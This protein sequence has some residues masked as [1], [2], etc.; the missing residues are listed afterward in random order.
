MTA[1][2]ISAERIVGEFEVKM[3]SCFHSS[4]LKLLNN[5]DRDG[6]RVMRQV[7][8]SEFNKA[9][10]ALFEH[11]LLLY[12]NGSAIPHGENYVSFEQ[13]LNEVFD[14]FEKHTLS[15]NS[16]NGTKLMGS[17]LEDDLGKLEA[18]LRREYRRIDGGSAGNGR[19]GSG[20]H[21]DEPESPV[22]RTDQEPRL[23]PSF[24]TI[25]KP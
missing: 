7:I 15:Y 22:G 16:T 8:I 2:A 4:M 23:V 12:P 3:Q 1:Q 14:D 6:T 25:S 21:A 18:Y 10:G 19:N 20:P 17:L 24:R 11:Y 13:R 9:R 5:N